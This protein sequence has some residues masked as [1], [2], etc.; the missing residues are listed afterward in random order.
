MTSFSIEFLFGFQM[1]ILIIFVFLLVFYIKKLKT[2]VREEV[3]N[4]TIEDVLVILEP[5]L[6]EA[7]ETAQIFESQIKE[8]SN[9][10]S[11]LNGKLDSRIISM[12][13]LLNRSETCLSSMEQ[14]APSMN[15]SHVYDQQKSI[16]SM[17][18]SGDGAEQIAQ[19]LSMPKGEVD[20][21]INLKK[22]FMSME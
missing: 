21:V 7:S 8:K 14:Q 12:N 17:Y 5:L 19:K 18:E 4:K 3:A 11:K 20:L 6:Q 13:L 9:L 22:K 2:S 10:I 16:L 15:N 1:I